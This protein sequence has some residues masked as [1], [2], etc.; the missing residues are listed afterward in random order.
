[1]EQLQLFIHKLF[2]IVLT[3]SYRIE[4]LALILFI[5]MLTSFW[6]LAK[7]L[8]KFEIFAFNADI[9]YNISFFVIYSSVY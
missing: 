2:L 5:H 8:V 7:L 6:K 3:F 9:I 4:T 1:M